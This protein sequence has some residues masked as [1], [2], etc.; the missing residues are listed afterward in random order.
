MMPPPLH[1]RDEDLEQTVHWM[2]QLIYTSRAVTP[3]GELK[4]KDLLEI[5]RRNNSLRGITGMLLH[6][7]GAFVQALE[8][9]SNDVR[10]T[11]DRI[12]ADPRHR[13]VRTLLTRDVESRE[14]PDWSMG[15][16]SVNRALLERIPGYRDV[17]LRGFE[18]ASVSGV[19]QHVLQAFL[20]RRLRSLA[21]G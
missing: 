20:D 10:S 2:R 1:D 7:E 4:L 13:E 15:Y 18:N 21:T 11:F 6:H 3:L 5:S 8:G 16:A 12:C 14:F 19:G 9:P 17:F